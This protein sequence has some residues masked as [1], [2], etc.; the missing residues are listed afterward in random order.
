MKTPIVRSRIQICGIFL[1]LLAMAVPALA[2]ESRIWVFTGQVI[3]DQARPVEGASVAVYDWR[4]TEQLAL[5][6]TAVDGRFRCELNVPSSE[7]VMVARKEGLALGWKVVNE[8]CGTTLILGRPRLLAGVVEDDAG[9]P[10]PNAVV[11]MT[12]SHRI[13]ARTLRKPEGWLTA[14]T[15]RDGRFT[16]DSI[17]TEAFADLQVKAPGRV[18]L[19][20]FREGLERGCQFASGRTDIRLVLGPEA[21]IQGKVVEEDA[22]RPVS[23]V[24]VAAVPTGFHQGCCALEP[25]VT[26]MEGRVR[27]TGLRQGTYVLQLNPSTSPLPD[28]VGRDVEVTLRAGQVLEDAKIPVNKGGILEV[29]VRDEEDIAVV[30]GALVRVSQS[31]LCEGPTDANG[32]AR[33]R[34]SAG[35]AKIL[36]HT[37]KEGLVRSISAMRWSGSIK[38]RPGDTP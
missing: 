20:T 17:P 11:S 12:L 38:G 35:E 7:V 32:L 22:G 33:F 16:F 36:E 19:C 1:C 34:L 31:H 30:P 25:A 23:G 18:S 2:I 37:R 6:K 15:D 29:A 27:F 14:K 5:V 4:V 28:W 10:V 13:F 9:Q 24:P 8:P 3:D 26:D 21:V